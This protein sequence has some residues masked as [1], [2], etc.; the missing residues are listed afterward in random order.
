MER[1]K[2]L[3]LFQSPGYFAV[4]GAQLRGRRP[5]RDALARF[6]PQANG[7]ISTPRRASTG[8]LIGDFPGRFGPGS[9]LPLLRRVRCM[10][11]APSYTRHALSSI[12]HDDR[13]L[14]GGVGDDL[15]A[16]PDFFLV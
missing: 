15:V 1:Q 5:E 12:E 11:P 3:P 4:A 13:A 6:R 8:N 14:L 10:L 2:S 7:G 9:L 16:L